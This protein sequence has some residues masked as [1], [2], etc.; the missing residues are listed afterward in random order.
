[1][2]IFSLCIQGKPTLYDPARYKVQ[3]R[4]LPS[5]LVEVYESGLEN[6]RKPWL[7]LSRVQI[8]T[9]LVEYLAMLNMNILNLY[10]IKNMTFLQC[11]FVC[12][13]L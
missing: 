8:H 7:A 3:L 5:Y 9:R 11:V 6:V 4:S 13:V 12:S 2:N 10:R 1:M